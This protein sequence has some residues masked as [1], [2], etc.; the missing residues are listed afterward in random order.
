MEL[1]LSFFGEKK[2]TAGLQSLTKVSATYVVESGS[3]AGQLT[4]HEENSSISYHTEIVHPF[5]GQDYAEVKI[6]LVQTVKKDDTDRFIVRLKTKE[7]PTKGQNH[8][9]VVIRYNGKLLTEP[10]ILQIP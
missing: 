1:Q 9:E 5:A 4:T 6:P 3:N 8:V 7:L 2:P 10:Q